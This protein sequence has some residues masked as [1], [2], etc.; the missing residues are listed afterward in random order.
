[1]MKSTEP[2]VPW[3]SHLEESLTIS[4]K[5]NTLLPYDPEIMHRGIYASEWKA[6]VQAKPVHKSL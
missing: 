1:M 4:T 3:Y 6:Y 5:L 2:N